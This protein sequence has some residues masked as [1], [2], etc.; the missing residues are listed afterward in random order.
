MQDI[1]YIMVTS[2]NN[3]WDKAGQGK[4]FFTLPLIKVNMDNGSPLPEAKTL[5]I[6]RSN[7]GVEK[8]WIG[9]SRNF[10]ND[11]YKGKPA[12]YFDIADLR[13]EPC[14]ERFKEYIDGWYEQTPENIID[15]PLQPP[16]FKKMETCSFAEFEQHCFHLL[17]LIGIHD[18]HTVPA[19]DS[20][21]RADGFFRFRSLTV[22]YDATTAGNYVVKKEQQIENYI[23]QLK[24]EKVAFGLNS[25]TIKDT[26][27]Q[28]WLIT[29]DTVVRP[30]KN[31]DGIKVK[32]IP[33]T[34]LIEI[35]DRRL[36]ER[37]DMEEL[38][39]LLKDI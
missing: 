8:S 13:P 36:R 1:K 24:E 22:M 15:D 6:K 32:G 11:N 39:N 25:Y 30:I 10:R 16:F 34:K 20:S 17:R 31:A 38:W 19:E 14:P 5:F 4:T 12:V 23:N 9:K 29:R 37:M 2:W 21:G 27:R 35:Y 3:Y 28:V 18:I 26:L 7:G 33:Y